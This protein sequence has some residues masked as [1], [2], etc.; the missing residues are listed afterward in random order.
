MYIFDGQNRVIILEPGVVEFSVK[1]LYS[2]WKDWVM[3]NDNAKFSNTFS[4]VG[5]EPINQTGTQVISPYFFLINNWKLRP[6]E[7]N[8]LLTINGNFLTLDGTNPIISTIGD[9]QV[10]VRTVLSVNSTTTSLESVI[11]TIK[12]DLEI[13]NQGLKNSSLFI[14]HKN[15][16]T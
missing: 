11:N 7:S 14:P 2:R 4:L 15:N 3:I 16:L 9:F 13:I 10:F 6:Q 1:D 5:G 12:N 8:H